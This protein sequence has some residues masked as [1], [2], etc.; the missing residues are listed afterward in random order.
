[1]RKAENHHAGLKRFIR[2]TGRSQEH[3]NRTMRKFFHQTPTEFVNG[4][5]LDEAAEALSRPDAKVLEIVYR[6]GFNNAS[7]FMRI[8]RRRFGTTPG[9]YRRTNRRIIEG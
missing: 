8:F 5:R 2:L 9:A 4:L 1:M 3:L 7:Y 6:T